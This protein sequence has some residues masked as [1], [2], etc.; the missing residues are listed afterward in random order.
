MVALNKRHMHR[1]KDSQ[2]GERDDSQREYVEVSL[3]SE[4]VSRR[5]RNVTERAEEQRVKFPRRE[6]RLIAMAAAKIQERKREREDPQDSQ[7]TLILDEAGSRAR[8]HAER[9]A[10]PPVW[11]NSGK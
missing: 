1:M 4:I 5:I 2:K 3:A 7:T 6:H 11:R 8:R 9:R 10:S